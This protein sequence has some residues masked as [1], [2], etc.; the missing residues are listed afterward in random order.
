MGLADAAFWDTVAQVSAVLGVGLI[1]EVRL[2]AKFWTPAQRAR[3]LVESA[4]FAVVG[5]GLFLLFSNALTHLRGGDS[6]ISPALADVALATTFFVLAT[7]PL[8]LAFAR[9]NSD[10][11]ERAASG[12]IRTLARWRPFRWSRRLRAVTSSIEDTRRRALASC[13]RYDERVD[14]M[15][16]LLASLTRADFPLGEAVN[17]RLASFMQGYETLHAGDQAMITRLA[18]AAVQSRTKLDTLRTLRAIRTDYVQARMEIR[19][20]VA[21]C[22]DNLRMV[23]KMR[24]DPFGTHDEAEKRLATELKYVGYDF[25]VNFP[26]SVAPVPDLSDTTAETHRL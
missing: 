10:L 13:E 20:M 26:V 1:L 15:T 21:S 17:E 11:A 5:F 23:E 6:L 14:D 2:A 4:F 16:D 3:R 25:L 12:L 7:Q 24:R 22:D 8:Y 9:A 18:N 19:E